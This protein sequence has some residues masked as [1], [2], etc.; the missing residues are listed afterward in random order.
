MEKPLDGEHPLSALCRPYRSPVQYRHVKYDRAAMSEPFCP[1]RSD[2]V[3]SRIN[4]RLIF[5]RKDDAEQTQ[6]RSDRRLRHLDNVDQNAD[7]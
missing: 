4:L 3:D 1:I 7:R 6:K 5:H 2:S